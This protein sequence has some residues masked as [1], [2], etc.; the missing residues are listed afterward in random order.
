MYNNNPYAQGGWYNPGNPLSINQTVSPSQPSIY[1]ALPGLR[2]CA[3]SCLTFAL[4]PNEPDILNCSVVGPRGSIHF[5]I[6]T[7]YSSA[8]V[9][10]VR[11]PDGTLMGYIE[12][13]SKTPYV[14]IPDS[15]TKQPASQ[16]LLL[17]ADKKS[18]FIY[19]VFIFRVF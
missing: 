5:M 3:D 17:S 11:Q 18:D 13:S 7:D 6:R 16:W 10:Y 2:N 12:W 15:V 4:C 14:C 8:P 9:T 1:G 19:C